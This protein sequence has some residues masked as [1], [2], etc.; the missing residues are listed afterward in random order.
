MH[1]QKRIFSKERINSKLPNWKFDF[2]LFTFD[3]QQI[4]LCDDNLCDYYMQQIS[5]QF[6]SER[7]DQRIARFK[8]Y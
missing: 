5:G 7:K 1:T 3:I 2:V 6:E 8:F 4:V